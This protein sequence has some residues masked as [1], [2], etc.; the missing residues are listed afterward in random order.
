MNTRLVAGIVAAAS[1]VFSACGS[2][3]ESTSTQDSAATP[4]ASDFNDADVMFAQMMMPH[5][6]QAIEM[7]DIALDPTVGASAEIVA[8]ATQIKAAQD[9]EI[10][11]MTELLTSWGK[12]TM[13]DDGM[14][15]SSMM[16]GMLSADELD[17]LAT[18][19]GP[20]FDKAWAAAMIA[21]HEGAILMANDVLKDGSNTAI[22]DLANAIV[23]TQQTEIDQLK[24][25]L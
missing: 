4:A 13:P 5:H 2:S 18:M 16:S 14:D 19:R 24:T 7:A 1:L 20:D 23:A 10:A 21:H 9:P 11:Q 22:L 3:G 17:S 12:S 25:L 15:H 6:E 8:L